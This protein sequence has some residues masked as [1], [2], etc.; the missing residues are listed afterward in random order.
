MFIE[1]NN[2]GNGWFIDIWTSVKPPDNNWYNMRNTYWMVP[3]FEEFH[4]S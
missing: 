1:Y 3:G 4:N 2:G